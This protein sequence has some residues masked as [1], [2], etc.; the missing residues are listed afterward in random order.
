MIWFD[1]ALRIPT[2]L[3]PKPDTGCLEYID[4]HEAERFARQET[5]QW[6]ELWPIWASLLSSQGYEERRNG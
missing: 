2:F 5:Y 4:R 1:K 6:R 3:M